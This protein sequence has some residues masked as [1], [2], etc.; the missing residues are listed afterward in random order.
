M[1][2]PTQSQMMLPLL[3]ILKVRGEAR[4]KDIYDELAERIGLSDDDRNRTIECGGQQVNEYER[5]VRWTRQTAVVKGL[6][7][8]GERAAWRITE[9]AKAKLG[10]IRQGTI[11]TFAIGENGFLLWANAEDAVTVIEK[12]SVQLLMTSPP[13]P[14]QRSREY[15]NAPA[16]QWV[17]WMLS[18]I[19]R[20]LP[21]LT[22]DG[23]MML[24]IGPT[25]KKGLPAQALHTERLLVSLEDKLGVFLLQRL[26]WF[27]PTRM[28]SIP[29]AGKSRMRVTASVE[30]I[31]WLSPNA[32][33][34]G[35]NLSV[36]RP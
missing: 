13:Y 28:P 23:S 24:N 16:E 19:E 20:F 1:P 27:S 30:P 35:N 14:L 15:G 21:L 7:Q 10:N 22:N 17:D 36:L 9:T 18:H 29:H 5:T 11:V 31:L 33:A 6:I 4:P 3:E 34:Y 12:E 32:K 26:D 25:W 8:K 2:I